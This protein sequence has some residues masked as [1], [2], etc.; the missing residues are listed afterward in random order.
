MAAKLAAAVKEKEAALSKVKELELRHRKVREAAHQHKRRKT[1]DTSFAA[2][3]INSCSEVEWLR[4]RNRS[5]Y[6]KLHGDQTCCSCYGERQRFMKGK[7]IRTGDQTQCEIQ[8]KRVSALAM[9]R[10]ATRDEMEKAVKRIDCFDCFSHGND[11]HTFI[12]CGHMV[13]AD[14]K[15]K[16][17]MGA[18]CPTLPKMPGKDNWPPAVVQLSLEPCIAKDICC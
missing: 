11:R 17:A 7:R 3:A 18:P 12:P 14:C 5:P 15:A 8:E 13:F 2:A 4:H 9:E 10:D 6:G 16:Y 1:D